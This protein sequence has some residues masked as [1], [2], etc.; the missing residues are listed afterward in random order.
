VDLSLSANKRLVLKPGE[1]EVSLFEDRRPSTYQQVTSP[2]G[3]G[4][5]VT[6]R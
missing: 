5:F 2:T 4:G 1:Y 3:D 6:S